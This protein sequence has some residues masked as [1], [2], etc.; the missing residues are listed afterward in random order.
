M[1]PTRDMIEANEL[2]RLLAAA[3]SERDRLSR[4]IVDLEADVSHWRQ[5]FYRAQQ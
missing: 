1:E 5:V 2:R 4:K 3:L